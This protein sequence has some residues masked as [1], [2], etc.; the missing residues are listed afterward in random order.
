MGEG[1]LEDLGLHVRAR[2]SASSSSLKAPRGRTNIPGCSMITCCLL[3]LHFMVRLKYSSSSMA[4]L[5][6]KELGNS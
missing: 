3:R 2:G 6:A 5:L 4:M 1:L